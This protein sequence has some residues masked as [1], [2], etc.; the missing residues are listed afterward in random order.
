MSGGSRLKLL[1]ERVQKQHGK[2]GVEA[3]MRLMDRPVA[4]QS[5][6]HNALFVPQDGVV[7]VA[8]ATHDKPA[9]ET[10][11]VRFDLRALLSPKQIPQATFPAHDT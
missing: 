6:L 4:M 1:R 11:Y 8:N 7:Y 10:D 9:A 3:A 2:I 5:N